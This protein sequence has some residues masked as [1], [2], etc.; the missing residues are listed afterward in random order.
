MIAAI[1]QARM[2]SNRLP[3]KVMKPLL[4]MPMIGRQIERVRMAHTLD[5][6]LVATSTEPE[7]DEL[8]LYCQNSGVHCFRGSL[9]NVLERYCNGAA[10]VDADVI[11]RLTGD[12]PLTDAIIIDTLVAKFSEGRYDY[13]SNTLKPTFPDG[14]DAEVFSR[15]ALEKAGREA[16]LPSERE[17]VTPFLKNSATFTK[18]NLENDV[19]L[20][21]LRWT[22]DEP[23]DFVLIERIFE[24]LYPMSANFGMS[25]ILLL[26]KKYPDWA[27]LNE[28]ISRDEGYSKSLKEDNH[29][30]SQP[31]TKSP[32]QNNP[33]KVR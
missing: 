8:A 29:V 6:I 2:S 30:Q 3:G 24:T 21:S 13:V 19:D 14:L 25:D 10:S 23:S 5:E 7:D 32:A 12:C 4:G 22:V 33:D 26:L 11:V 15:A 17:H 28:K 9:D 31:H 16:S 20:G 1:I 18:F 27:R